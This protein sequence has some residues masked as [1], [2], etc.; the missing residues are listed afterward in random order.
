M[1]I[2]E[3]IDKVASTLGDEDEMTIAYCF[4]VTNENVTIEEAEA[5]MNMMLNVNAM[6]M[7]FDNDLI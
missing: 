5:V 1:S 6:T 7:N 3:M 4:Y 2:V